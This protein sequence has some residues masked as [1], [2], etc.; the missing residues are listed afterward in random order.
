MI[1]LIRI[2]DRLVHGQVAFTWTP[3]LGADC[4]LIANDKVAKD[5]FMKMTLNLA[6]PA[7]TKLLIKTVKDAANFLNDEKSRNAK[8]LVLTNNIKDAAALAADVPEITSINFGGLR[9]KEGSKLISKAVAVNDEDLIIIRQM[10]AKGLE[11]EVRQVPTDNR[12]L[13]ESLI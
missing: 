6:K 9:S 12:R 4:L 5:E 11:L 13:V 8:V 7:G 1:K 3:A 10:L 2:D